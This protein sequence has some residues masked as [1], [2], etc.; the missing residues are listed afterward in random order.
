[1]VTT[2]TTSALV[3]VFGPHALPVDWLVSVLDTTVARMAEFTGCRETGRFVPPQTAAAS[4][5]SPSR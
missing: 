5:S 4:V 3:V 2:A 1:M